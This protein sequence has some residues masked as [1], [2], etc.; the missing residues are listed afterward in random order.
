MKVIARAAIAVALLAPAHLRAEMIFR[1]SI[2]AREASVTLDGD[3]LTYRYG[4]PGRPEIEITGGPATGNPSYHREL[5]ARGEHQTLRFRA[6]GHSY[7]V[8]S[9]WVAPTGGGAEHLEAGVIVMRGDAVVREL[10]CRAD[11]DMREYPIFQRL[12]QEPVSPL[13]ERH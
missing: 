8:H 5:F 11:G 13:P 12:P 7:L 3:L 10:R 9:L 2:G 1:C 4:R 6:A